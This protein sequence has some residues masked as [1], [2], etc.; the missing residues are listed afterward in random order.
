MVLAGGSE[1]FSS[2]RE[3][4]ERLRASGSALSSG[5]SGRTEPP[6]PVDLA[7]TVRDGSTVLSWQDSGTTLPAGTTAKPWQP[8]AAWPARSVVTSSSGNQHYYKSANLGVSGWLEP[9]W[10]TD[11]SNV[12][13]QSSLSWVDSGTSLPAGIQAAKRWL[14]N[15]AYVAGDVISSP[16]NGHFYSALQGGVS[17]GAPTHPFPISVT[18]AAIGHGRRWHNSLEGCGNRT[19]SGASQELDPWHPISAR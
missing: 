18:P 2:L 3:L 11:G 8:N 7:V 15:S 4:E 13:E 6:L 10:P 5:V 19:T 14:P 17:G 16:G 9:N 12:T 1:V